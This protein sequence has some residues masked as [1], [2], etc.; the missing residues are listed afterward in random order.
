MLAQARHSALFSL[1]PRARRHFPAS[2]AAEV[3]AAARPALVGGDPAGTAAFMS[4]GWLV[5]FFPTK[6]VPEC[7][8]GVV[9]H[10]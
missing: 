4:L 2:A 3:W 6:R 8:P 5:M 1:V 9:S 7:E 10:L